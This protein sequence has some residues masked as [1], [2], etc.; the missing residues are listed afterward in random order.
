MNRQ[1]LYGYLQAA[2]ECEMKMNLPQHLKLIKSMNG[3]VLASG[4]MD[5]TWQRRSVVETA[6]STHG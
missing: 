6:S 3:L 4:P 1:L 5:W 2:L